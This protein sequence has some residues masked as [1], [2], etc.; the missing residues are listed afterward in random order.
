MPVSDSDIG[1][2]IRRVAGIAERAH[3]AVVQVQ[4]VDGLPAVADDH[5]QVAIPVHVPERDGTR[6]SHFREI[7]S[8]EPDIVG[9]T[10]IQVQLVGL[11]IIRGDHIR[12]AVP[13]YVAG[14][15][16][17]CRLSGP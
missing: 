8:C 1:A 17:N 7:R 3:R 13:V 4:P 16:G 15:N 2:Y 11:T 14:R 5:V 9:H 10:F 6:Q 12:V